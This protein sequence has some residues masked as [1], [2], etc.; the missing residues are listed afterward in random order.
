MYTKNFVIQGQF[1]SLQNK[2]QE[3]LDICNVNDLYHKST[4]YLAIRCST[5]SFFF[6][7][8]Y[9]LPTLHQM[10]SHSYH[11]IIQHHIKLIPFC[12]IVTRYFYL[13]HLMRNKLNV[14]LLISC[15]YRANGNCILLH[16]DL[17]VQTAQN[18]A[19]IEKIS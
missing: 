5:M 6:Q 10:M 4:F 12:E 3:N 1:F 11:G 17:S 14:P 18:E 2:V 7:A 9:R 15:L 8:K 13:I 19:S 16:Y